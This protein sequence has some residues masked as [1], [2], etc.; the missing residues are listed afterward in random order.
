MRLLARQISKEE[1]EE[2]VFISMTDMTVGFLFIVL[3]LL[4]FFASQ[5]RDQDVVNRSEYDLVKSRLEIEIAT[6]TRLEA[7]VSQL[8]QEISELDKRVL[9]LFE[10]N[11]TMSGE[12]T[13]LKRQ[14]AELRIRFQKLSS[15]L[16]DLKATNADLE[17]L[18]SNQAERIEA[19]LTQVARLTARVAQLESEKVDI[20]DLEKEIDRLDSQ[21]L[22]LKER[23]AFLSTE[24][25]E[26][27]DRITELESLA[28]KMREEADAVRIENDRLKLTVSE[29]EARIERLEMQI[30]KLNRL[31]AELE[32]QIAALEQ[33]DPLEAYL[34]AV[35]RERNQIVRD[36]R[37]AII[38]DFPEL[39]GVITAESDAL[40]F[41]G[42]GLFA[43]GQSQL[44][45]QMVPVIHRI[46]ER[47]H[48][49]LPCYTLGLSA[50]SD[51]TC[52]P[53]SAVIEAIQIE[54]HTDDVGGLLY[55]LN[56]SA[57]RATSTFSTMIG[58]E[59]GLRRHQNL[60]GQPV[61]SVAGYGPDRPVT[62]NN[63]VAGKAENRRIDLRFIMVTPKSN[64]EIDRI[65]AAL[66][67]ARGKE[68]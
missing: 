68:Q 35:A 43:S 44:R 36:L 55:N 47:L 26:L 3:I 59:S 51:G 22:G 25:S 52:N 24:N 41:Q 14:L 11:I 1:E 18:V 7:K 12:I 32:A 21:I 28:A 8:E 67:E 40:R 54:G 6:R 10:E 60:E 13:E 9:Q 34:S 57:A 2:S 66:T 30:S 49:I 39:E 19:L 38:Q 46:A 33:I 62:S 63:T 16:D 56:L 29:R 37:D 48:Q 42:Q 27:K 15:E 31:I 45:A 17:I 4:A 5:F 50:G 53:S 64:A 23:V 58:K 65:R 20:L 61:L